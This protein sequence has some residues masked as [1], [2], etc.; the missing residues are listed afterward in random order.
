[1]KKKKY[2]TFMGR[3]LL[4]CLI[5]A[6]TVLSPIGASTVGASEQSS[7]VSSKAKTEEDTIYVDESSKKISLFGAFNMSSNIILGDVNNDGDINSIDFAL[8]RMHLLGIKGGSVTEDFVL[9]ADINMDGIFNSIDLA[10]MRGYLLGKISGYPIGNI[11]SPNQPTPT[12]TSTPLPSPTDSSDED[13]FTDNIRKASYIVL[14]GAEVHGKINHAGDEDY[15]LFIPP[16]DGQ[17]RVE[18]FTNVET[19]I[20]YL[21]QEK[22]EGL[23]IHYNSFGTYTSKDGYYYIQEY[24]TKGTK[25][26]LGVKNRKDKVSLDSYIIKVTRLN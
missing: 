15:M 25:Y 1:M 24:L 4:I 23:R 14:V 3:F 18:I 7:K 16:S 6:L 26:F 11:P 22:E 9:A 21:Y 19:S 10:I 12:P 20:A 17:Y 13:D 5:L 8:M 2:V